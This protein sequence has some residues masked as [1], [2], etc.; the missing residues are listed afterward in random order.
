MTKEQ[1]GEERFGFHFHIAVHYQRELGQELKQ[2]RN[3][4]AGVDAEAME[5]C[6]L[7]ACSSCLAQSPFL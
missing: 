6:C 5:G 3:P 4:E 1:V 2:G 7:L